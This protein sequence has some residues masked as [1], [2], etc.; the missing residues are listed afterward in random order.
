MN[1][2]SART[3][4]LATL[5]INQ[6]TKNLTKKSFQIVTHP[7]GVHLA[8][9]GKSFTDGIHNFC[10]CLS[11]MGLYVLSAKFLKSERRL[12]NVSCHCWF[13]FLQRARL[14]QSPKSP[15]Q[16]PSTTKKSFP[17]QKKAGC[18]GSVC[19]SL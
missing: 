12:V 9:K 8:L 13:F 6:R 17:W 16:L 3:W 10:F 19:C 15:K 7:P 2:R 11:N 4:Q 5:R 1:C 14:V 18:L